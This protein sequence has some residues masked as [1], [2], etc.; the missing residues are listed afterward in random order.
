MRNVLSL[1]T[2][3]P[4]RI[5]LTRGD[6]GI[7]AY[8]ANGFRPSMVLDFFRNFYVGVDRR[9]QNPSDIVTYGTPGLALMTDSDGFQKWN[10]H[11]LALNSATPATQSITVVSGNDY[12]VEI[13]GTGS[14]TL[15]GA[16][17]GT[18]TAGSPVEVTAS[19]TT[20]TLTVSGSPSTLSTYRSDQGGMA[21]VPL[22]QRVAG[23]ETYVPTTSA[24]VYIPREN[25]YL[26]DADTDTWINNGLFLEAEARTQLLHTTNVLVTQSHTVT[27]VPHTLHFTGTG[28]VTLSG[29]STAGPLVGTGTGNQNRVSLTFTPTAA[30][31]TLTV[32]G[33]VSDAQLEVGSTPSSYI[34]NPAASGTVTRAAETA[35]I[36]PENNPL[37]E[38]GPELVTN[39]DGSTLT[40]WTAAGDTIAVADGEFSVTGGTGAGYLYQSFPTVIGQNYLLSGDITKLGNNFEGVR[41]SDNSGATINVE[42]L[43]GANG[44][45]GSH[46]LIF[47][48]TAA[49]TFIILQNNDTVNAAKFD[50][51]SVKSL[52]MP[53]ALS[54]GLKGKVTGASSTFINW[55]ADADNGLLVQSSASDFTFTQEAATVVDTVTGGSYTSGINVPFNIASR[56]GNTFI[57]GAVDGT[58]LTANTTPTALADLTTADFQIGPDFMGHITQVV[59]YSDDIEDTGLE[60]ITQ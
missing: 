59:L 23:S 46:T 42:N 11:N 13:T 58:A 37:I 17:T 50:N 9:T 21:P 48:A 44:V 36:E 7:N 26:Y 31:L 2:G 40:G 8:S 20:L 4:N 35:V 29:A 27:A 60:E 28:T 24:A 57:N 12:T 18:V 52:S 1:L 47:T 22:G 54:I 5:F 14:V 33:T 19:T 49:T 39:G 25:S 43:T 10:P 41:K 56:H 53:T 55:T 6:S 32:T 45:L 15:S 38:V 30:S 3:A 16:G 34:P 51:I